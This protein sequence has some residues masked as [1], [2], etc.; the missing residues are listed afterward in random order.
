MLVALSEL[1]F[2]TAAAALAY[3]YVGY[4]VVVWCLAQLRPKT[5]ATAPLTPR[6]SVVVACCNEAEA[7]Q[8]RV[9]N[10]L[11]SEYPAGS[12]EIIL[13]SD[14]STDATNDIARS[15]V[16][17]RIGLVELAEREGKAAALNAGV[18]LASGDVVVFADAR[19]QFEP[20]AIRELVSNFAD[21][22]VGAVAGEL[23]LADSRTSPTGQGVALYWRYESWIR[24]N[25]SRFDSTVG[26]T[27]AIYAI[28]RELWSPI[29][30]GTILDDVYVPMRIALGGHRVV[31]EDRARAFDT[32]SRTP[33]QEFR[34]K[35]RTLNGN[36]QLVQLLPRLLVPVHRLFFQFWSH[37]LMRLAAPFLL[38]LLFAASIAAP[39]AVYKAALAMQAIFY[40]AAVPAAILNG[41]GK[42]TRLLNAAYLFSVMNAAA[43]VGLFYFV[44]GK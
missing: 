39:G 14:G 12:L 29:P 21:P 41:R 44:I 8:R 10:L 17:E 9:E 13:V 34:R 11:N 22:S 25:E 4:P 43:L 37:K 31:L 20:A 2:W 30:A 40:A 3:I 23:V 32:V 27:G 15:L 36:Y 7:I 5:I 16:S 28:R 42:Q 19:Q 26:A 24:R 33:S 1:L 18:R 35:A 38:L 6:V